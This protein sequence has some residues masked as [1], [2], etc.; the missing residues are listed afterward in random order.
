M[1]ARLYL[2]QPEANKLINEFFENGNHAVE[3]IDDWFKAN[4]G[5][6]LLCEPMKNKWFVDLKTVEAAIEFKLRYL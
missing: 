5:C 4:Y 1:S 2:S 3:G 6:L